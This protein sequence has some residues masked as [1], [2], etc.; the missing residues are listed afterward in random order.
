MNATN[1][2]V[3][4][5]GI[6]GAGAFSMML[7][8]DTTQ[9]DAVLGPITV[10]GYN[11]LGMHCMNEDFSELAILPPFN[12]LRAQVVRRGI[13]PDIITSEAVVRYVIPTNMRSADKTNFWRYAPQL[14]GVSLE[15]DVG[16][17]GNRMSGI[18]QFDAVDGHWQAT[19]IP[20]TPILDSGMPNPY[21]VAVITATKDGQ[22]GTTHAVVPVSTEISCNLCHGSSTVSVAKD[23]LLDHDAVHGTNLHEQKPVLCASCHAD[24]ALGTPGV[25]GVPNLSSAM[26]SAHATRMHL[27]DLPNKCYAC[28]PGIR[29]QCQR[30]VH[31]AK[32][33]QCID[34]HGG[35][36][37]VGDPKRQPWIDEPRC[38]DCHNRP[39]FEFE[40]PGKL[41]KNSI[42]HKGIHCSSCHGSPHA[43][44]PTITAVDNEQAIALQGHAGVIDTCIVCH[45]QQP[46][47]PFFH[48]VDD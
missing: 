21:P 10:F 31:F 40:Q 28:H 29:T 27:V 14:F 18:M 41:F 20:I 33:I 19:G 22:T 16:L 45:T 32:N 2:L 4:V 5:I 46:T 12:T 24:N 39:G 44:T 38:G 13:E 42:G 36:W 30:D 35:M 8:G 17:T 34:C 15:P 6:A 47:D 23:I 25:P 37:A 26:H 48:K 11:E 9:Q 3:W 1:R 43:I 7:T